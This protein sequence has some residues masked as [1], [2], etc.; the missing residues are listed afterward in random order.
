MHVYI[1]SLVVNLRNWVCDNWVY[2]FLTSASSTIEDIYTKGPSLHKVHPHPDIVRRSAGSHQ[3]ESGG[4]LLKSQISDQICGEDFLLRF[5]N[6]P[7]FFVHP[8]SFFCLVHPTLPQAIFFPKISSFW[9]LKSSLSGRE[10]PTCRGWVLGTVLDGVAPQGKKENRLF[11][12]REKRWDLET[13]LLGALYREFRELMRS[14]MTLLGK[15]HKKS[16]I[17]CARGRNTRIMIEFCLFYQGMSSEFTWVLEN[18]YTM[19]PV[20][21]SPI[22]GIVWGFLRGKLQKFAQNSA[23]QNL[24]RPLQNPRQ[25]SAP[26]N[27]QHEIRTKVP[28]TV[29]SPSVQ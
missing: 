3:K 16:I 27:P 28:N 7:P 14:L 26:G 25:K 29:N 24:H 23:L 19:H 15:I 1:L 22:N 20:K 2:Q 21:K 12:A 18:P 4:L 13:S 10:M 6:F 11:L 17:I 9:D 8:F 5:F